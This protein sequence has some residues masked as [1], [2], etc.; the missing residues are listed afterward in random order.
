MGKDQRSRKYVD[1]GVQG[2]LAR[3]LIWQWIAFL[4][5]G[6][7]VGFSFQVIVDPF[8]P[9]DQTLKNVWSNQGPFL[10]VALLL[11]PFFISDSITLSHRFVGP[12]V[13]LRSDLRRLIEAKDVADAPIM[14][15]RP[16]DMW[17]ELAFEYNRI[18]ER[19][20]E[21]Q[22]GQVRR[23]KKELVRK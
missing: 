4:S 6:C 2:A 1:P 5:I 3:R 14:K 15:L 7:I 19:C 12:V 23:D 11:I 17:Q 20:L 9:L 22:S 13:R 18:R 8:V 16:S 10:I 21:L